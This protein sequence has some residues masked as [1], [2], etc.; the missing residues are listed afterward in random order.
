MKDVY[1]FEGRQVRTIVINSEIYFCASDVGAVLGLTNVYRQVKTFDK[2]VHTMQTPTQGGAQDIIYINEPNLYRL[3][4][5]S[6]KEN[7]RR[8]Q[9]WI[10]ESVIPQ[11]RKTGGYSIT[12]TLREESTRA[13]NTLTEEWKNSGICEPKEYAYL[14]LEEYRMLRLPKG[15]RKKD[16]NKEEILLLQALESM[17]ALNLHFNP[18]NGYIECRRSLDSTADNL[19]SLIED[20]R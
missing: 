11:I 9:D 20:R 8:F 4:F 2:G 6:R 10:F 19:Q 5:K 15:K 17:E 12:K 3:I 13:R 18:A 16:M 7:A 14:T 1:K